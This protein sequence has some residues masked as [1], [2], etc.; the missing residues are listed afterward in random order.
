MQQQVVAEVVV[1]IAPHGV[2][3]VRFTR[4]A[5]AHLRVFELDQE[6]RPLHAVV[7]RLAA[8]RMARPGE[9]ELLESGALQAL[10]VQPRGLLRQTLDVRRR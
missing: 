2:D 8:L 10:Q 4:H 7:V 1:G 9:G 6:A 3:V 5:A